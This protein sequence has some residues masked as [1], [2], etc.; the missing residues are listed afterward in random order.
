MF[1]HKE[2]KENSLLRPSEIYSK[3]AIPDP[4]V[5]SYIN[6]MEGEEK[7]EYPDC[8]EI[9]LLRFLHLLF[10]GEREEG[11]KIGVID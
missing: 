11:R 5:Y 6:Y 8:L 9:S 2:E 1:L 4:V 10:G 7:V 3:I